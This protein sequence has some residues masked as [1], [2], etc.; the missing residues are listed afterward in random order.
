MPSDVSLCSRDDGHWYVTADGK[1][2]VGFSG[3]AAYEFALRQQKELAALL[4]G[5][6]P[7]SSRDDDAG[8]PFP[9][10]R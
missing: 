5:D 10:E 8:D 3:P 2:L 4:N 9:T 7:E 1:Y 6:R